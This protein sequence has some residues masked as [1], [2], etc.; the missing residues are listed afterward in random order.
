[1]NLRTITIWTMLLALIATF[2]MV[3]GYFFVRES[4]YSNFSILTTPFNCVLISIVCNFPL[5]VSGII[6]FFLKRPISLTILLFSTIT[7]GIGM[8]GALCET[9]GYYSCMSGIQFFG[10]AYGWLF[11]MTPAWI[12]AIVLEILH[13]RTNQIIPP[14]P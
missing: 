13:R 6:L 5:F 12:I 14:E 7:Y 10:F 8:C 1:M 11:C 9:W 4:H 2:M 3:F